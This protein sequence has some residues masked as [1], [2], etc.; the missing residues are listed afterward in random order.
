METFEVYAI[1]YAELKA[2]PARDIFLSADLHEAPV[3]MDYFVWLIRSETRSIVVD[4]GFNAQ[5]AAKRGRDFLR[6]PGEGLRKL[7]VDP[8]EV[9][10]VIITHL[11]YDH[12]GN[13]PVFP[14][15]R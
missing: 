9:K 12:V 14:N 8:A 1:K 2:R 15:A 7:G 11:H 10:D 5:I 6:C 13:F 3:D 4:T